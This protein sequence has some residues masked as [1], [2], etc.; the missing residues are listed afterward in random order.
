MSY[1][2]IAYQTEQLLYNKFL[3]SLLSLESGKTTALGQNDSFTFTFYETI[4]NI[5]QLVTHNL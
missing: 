3:D 4:S 1:S 5:K 2:Q